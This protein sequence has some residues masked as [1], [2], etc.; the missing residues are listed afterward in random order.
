MA[1]AIFRDKVNKLGY[2]DYFNVIDSF[3]MTAFHLGD[4]PD[5][6]SIKTCRKNNVPIN[7]ASQPLSKSDYNKFDYLLGMDDFHLSELTYDKPKNSKAKVA[8]FGDWRSDSSF[9]KIVVDPYYSNTKAFEYN[10]EQ[11]N[12]FTDEFLKQEVGKLD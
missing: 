7:H 9:D 4:S 2:S 1:E 3:G 12:H 5:S 8:L 6:R 10:F 11:L